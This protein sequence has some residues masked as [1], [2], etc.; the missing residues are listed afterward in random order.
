MSVGRYLVGILGIAILMVVHEGGHYLAAR[1]FGMRVS[2]FSIGFGPTLF[3]HQPKGSPTVYQIALIPFLAY[4]QIAGLN[5][6]EEIDPKD[7]GSYANASLWA[8]IVTIAAG[9]LTNYFFASVLLLLGYSLGAK[10]HDY[11]S[12]R[13]HIVPEGPAAV[14]GLLEGDKIIAVN[15]ETVR[16]WEELPAKISAH[17]GEAIDLTVDRAGEVM[18]KLVTPGAR[19]EKDAGKIL[20]SPLLRPVDNFREA[21]E[22]SVKDPPEIVYESLVGIARL[23]TGKA[24]FDEMSGPLGIVK[25]TARQA[26][27]ASQLVQFL[28]A[29]SAYL[30]AFNLLPLPA[31]DGG[32]LLFLGIE[33]V[34]RRRPDAKVEA[35]VHAVGLLMLL[36]LMVIVTYKDIIRR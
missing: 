22:R 35:L 28:G 15:G 1:R 16:S 23:F 10:F 14:A 7:P 29:L 21:L 4:V 8:R 36:A 17:P 18:H 6:Y 24:K 13:V 31:L 9:P 32:R 5:P 20:I 2:R 12:M 19:G 3:K 11:E 30:G 26:E 33:A 34:S 25:E 27:K